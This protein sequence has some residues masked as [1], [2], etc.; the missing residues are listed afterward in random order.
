MSA[1]STPITRKS[2]SVKPRLRGLKA[3]AT[4]QTLRGLVQIGVAAL[5]TFLD[6]QLFQA[7]ISLP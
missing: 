3:L 2:G 6:V 7:V 5:I 4:H 1:Q